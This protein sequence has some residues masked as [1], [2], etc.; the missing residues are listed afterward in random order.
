MIKS[1][2]KNT[3]AFWISVMLIIA[4]FSCFESYSAGNTR[5]EEKVVRVGYFQDYATILEPA[6]EGSMGYGYDYLQEIAKYT[7]WNYQFIKCSWDEGITL[8][9][10]GKIDIFGPMQ[11]TE[12]REIFFDF[13][14]VQ[15]GMEYG[16]LFADKNS[17]ILYEDLDYFN[18]MR[19]GTEKENYY[20]GVME[21][22]CKEKGIRVTY[23]YTDAVDIGKELKAGL[24]DTYITGDL[25]AIPDTTVVA[26]LSFEPYYYATTKGNREIVEGINNALKN[27]FRNDKYFEQKLYEKYFSNRDISKPGI[28]KSEAELI[29]KYKKLTVGCDSNSRP[30]QYFDETTGQTSGISMDILKEVANLCG[31]EFEFIPMDG[32]SARQLEKADLWVGSFNHNGLKNLEYTDT[33]LNVPMLLVSDKLVNLSDKLTIAMYSY[34]GK[35]GAQLLKEYPQF[36][37]DKYATADEAFQSFKMKKADAMFVPAYTYDELEQVNNQELYCVYATDIKCR[38]NIGIS[39][40]FPKEMINIL[41]KGIASLDNDVINT[42]IYKNT[43]AGAYNGSISML[44]KDNAWLV[45]GLVTVF[46]VLLLIV[47]EASNKRLKSV[48]Y[49]DSSTGKS[50]LAKFRMDARALLNN[51]K[52]D[53]YMLVSIDVNNFKYINDIYGYETGNQVL[54]ILAEHIEMI[55]PGEII[56]TTRRS[57]DNFVFI[58]KT[59]NK[60]KIFESMSDDQHLRRD[61]QE[62]L[63]PDYNLTLSIGVYVI[64]QPMKN[65][66]VMLDYAN[67]AKKTVKGRVGNPIAEY[68]PEMDQHMELKKKITVGMEAGLLHGEFITCMQ[69][70]YSLADEKLIGAEVLVRWKHPELGMLSPLLFIPLFEENGFI[71]KLDMYIFETTCKMIQKWNKATIDKIPRISV[72]ISRV[73]LGRKNLVK[74]L[75]EITEKYEIQ[76]NDMEIEITEGTLERNA[77]RII[78]IINDLKSVGFYVSIDDFGSGYSS[79]SILKDMPADIIKIDKEFL[80]ETFDSQKGKKIINSIIKMSKELKLETVAE[81]IETRE[82]AEA[83]K[84]MNCDVA[85]GYY[86]ARPMHPEEFE[87]MILRS[88]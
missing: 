55:L 43:S 13:P 83:L 23:V 56:L 15:M 65:I 85:Q 36:S 82:Q 6:N 5:Q 29:K 24:Y 87:S 1:G 22:Y 62:I 20:T 71:E 16:V 81:G 48:L 46:F 34:D 35:N 17:G 70:K 74:E 30:L 88:N 21:E 38:M 40:R 4:I 7:G 41:N 57:A 45:L 32:K 60:D 63:G 52:P 28:T 69:P 11:K 12:E 9:R 10:E 73:T 14:N 33:Y 50:S 59:C 53:E 44:V 64:H 54:K 37:V 49:I 68:T 51:A 19:V 79:L 2:I 25:Q 75:K 86:F 3:I 18:G 47:I 27:I 26:R 39:E 67:I 66:S 8:L 42:I 76:T 80:S 84:A 31:L 77:D 72:N 61:V 78:K 58:S